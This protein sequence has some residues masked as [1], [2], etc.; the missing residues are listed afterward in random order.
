MRRANR[1]WLC[2]DASSPPSD[3]FS[4]S[5]CIGLSPMTLQKGSPVPYVQPVQIYKRVE[6]D[7]Y[8]DRT[9]KTKNLLKIVGQAWAVL[10]MVPEEDR[11]SPLSIGLISTI[12]L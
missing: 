11:G 6:A 3:L 5:L 7:R 12:V 2:W 10:R 1:R 4:A 9:Y 8:V